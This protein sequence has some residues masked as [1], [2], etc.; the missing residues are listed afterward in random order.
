MGLV[1]GSGFYEAALVMCV[2]LI[3]VAVGL[4]GLEGKH[5]KDSSSMQFYIEYAAEIPFS[6]IHATLRNNRW[7]LSRLEYIE[8]TNRDI[9]RAIIDVQKSGKNTDKA[10]LLETLRNTNGVLFVEEA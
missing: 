8:G 10:A 7:Y 9:N 1:I 5:L 4:N 6:T 2:F 3:L